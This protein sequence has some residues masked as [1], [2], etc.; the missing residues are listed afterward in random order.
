MITV[1]KS[2]KIRNPPDHKASPIDELQFHFAHIIKK[3]NLY[4]DYYKKEDVKLCGTK[5]IYKVT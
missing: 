2:K 4:T 1:N 5:F 3:K